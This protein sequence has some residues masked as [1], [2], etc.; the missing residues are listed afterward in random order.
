MT[1]LRK[2]I[3]YNDSTWLPL[4]YH[5]PTANFCLWQVAVWPVP[6]AA[7]MCA[8]GWEKLPGVQLVKTHWSDYLKHQDQ[9][10]T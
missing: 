3:P 2:P 4:P 1:T 8:G 9:V 5:V 10:R 6:Y 7:Y